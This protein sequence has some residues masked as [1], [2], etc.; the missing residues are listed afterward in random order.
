MVDVGLET[1]CPT[2]KRCMHC[3]GIDFYIVNLSLNYLPALAVLKSRF[4]YFRS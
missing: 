2:S 3:L 4:D 1:E